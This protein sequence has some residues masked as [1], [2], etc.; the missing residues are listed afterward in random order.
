MYTTDFQD[1][2][3]DRNSYTVQVKNFDPSPPEA[4]L[5][6]LQGLK[7]NFYTHMIHLHL[8]QTTKISF[9]TSKPHQ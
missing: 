6:F 4:F 2:T 5:N 9:N 7:K 1:P 3:F 8:Q